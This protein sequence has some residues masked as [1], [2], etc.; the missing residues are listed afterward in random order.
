MFILI[1]RLCNQNQARTK[2]DQKAISFVFT[3]FEQVHLT[4]LSNKF[5]KEEVLQNVGQN[6]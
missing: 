5:G 1:F 6:E 4:I 2:E 3:H